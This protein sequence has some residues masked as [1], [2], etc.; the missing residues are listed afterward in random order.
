[1]SFEDARENFAAVGFVALRDNPA[2]PWTPPVEIP[3]D[4]RFTDFDSGR[5]SIDDN[6]DATTVRFSP[7]GNTKDLSEAACH[8]V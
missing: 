6:T 5:T 4:I 7:R 8:R 3:L 2:L 1:L